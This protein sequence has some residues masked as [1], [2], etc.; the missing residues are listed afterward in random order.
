MTSALL[1]FLAQFAHGQEPP[2]PTFAHPDFSEAKDLALVKDAKRQ[3]KVLRLTRADTDRRGAVWH[4][5]KQQVAGGFETV[6]RFQFTEQDPMPQYNGADGLAFVIQNSGL[7]AI[8]SAG[9]SGGFAAGDAGANPGGKGIQLS[10]AVFFDTYQNLNAGDPSNNYVSICANGRMK[11]M[12]WPPRRLA[13]TPGLSVYL[14]DGQIHTARV[15]Y[16][17]P[18]MTVYL[19]DMLTPLLTAAVN[20]S[21]I[22]DPD[23]SAFVGFTASTGGGYQNHDL[24]SWAFWG[25]RTGVDSNMAVVSSNIS[26]MK[27]V[28]LPDRTLCTPGEAVVE[29]TGPAQFHVILPANLEWGASIPNPAGLIVRIRN[30]NGNVCWETPSGPFS[31]C[32]GPSGSGAPLKGGTGFVSPQQDAGSLVMRTRQGRTYFSVNDRS[33][34]SFHDNV[35]Y[36]EFDVVLQK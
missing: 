6:F 18:L 27:T 13:F 33:G 34:D 26:F 5:Q 22:T 14:K 19:D 8:G 24:V 21:S 36:F 3:Q 23:G 29:E 10:F 9:G 35:G 32:N 2:K 30:A 16:K 31:G 15:I 4:R 28:C 1:I 11:E 12:Q 20:L 7:K 25:T 17:P